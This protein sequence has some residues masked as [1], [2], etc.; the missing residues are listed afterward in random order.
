MVRSWALFS[1]FSRGVVKVSLKPASVV[2]P[3]RDRSG[4]EDCV[5][6]AMEKSL[7]NTPEG[8]W[9]LGLGVGTPRGK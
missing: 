6:Q 5:A 4:S 9:A 3:D 8:G 1:S 7:L 2:E